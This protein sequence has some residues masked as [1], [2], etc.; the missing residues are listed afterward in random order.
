MAATLEWGR[1]SSPVLW[2]AYGVVDAAA[3]ALSVATHAML[4]FVLVLLVVFLLC[5]V[6]R[7]LGRSRAMWP[8]VGLAADATI[9]AVIFIY[10]GPQNA[11][12]EYPELSVAV[13][14]LPAL[15]LFAIS[16]TSVAGRVFLRGCKISAAEIT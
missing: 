7:T 16:G 9:W 13:L 2:I 5:E 14:L 12:P 6:S 3:I 11:R 8:L 1:E 10:S 15:L 4:P